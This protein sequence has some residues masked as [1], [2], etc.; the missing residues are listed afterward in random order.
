MAAEQG[1]VGHT[2]FYAI[3]TT[4]VRRQLGERGIAKHQTTERPGEIVIGCRT[5][6]GLHAA[7]RLEQADIAADQDDGILRVLERDDA[8][9]HDDAHRLAG[10]IAHGKVRSDVADSGVAHAHGECPQR[11]MRDAEKSLAPELRFTTAHDESRRRSEND[12]R[13]VVEQ[14]FLALADEGGVGARW[15]GPVRRALTLGDHKSRCHHD[16]GRGGKYAV[17]TPPRGSSESRRGRR[18]HPCLHFAECTLDV[19]RPIRRDLFRS[20]IERRD[21]PGVRRIG[22]QP[23]TNRRRL[24]GRRLTGQ[25]SADLVPVERGSG[26]ESSHGARLIYGI[27]TGPGTNPYPPGKIAV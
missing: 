3:P 21:Q 10:I 24:I 13:A 11:V 12:L 9:T 15:R 22:V 14:H 6:V 2:D 27:N 5:A 16:H 23:T 8:L 4:K 25:I 20:R 19:D 18:V 17:A 7:A 1:A 26:G